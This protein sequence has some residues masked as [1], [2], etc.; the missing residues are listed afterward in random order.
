[1]GIDDDFFRLGGNSV[2]TIKLVN[3]I[4]KSEKMQIRIFDVYKNKS[5]RK[6]CKDYN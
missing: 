2:L 4:N 6:L 5:V 3:M 1:M